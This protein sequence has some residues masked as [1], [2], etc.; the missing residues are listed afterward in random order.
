MAKPKKQVRTV[1]AER[2][3]LKDSDGRT[4]AELSTEGSLAVLAL[5]DRDE[6]RQLVLFAGD[7]G[8]SVVLHTANGEQSL[9]L[10][11]ISGRV[12]LISSAK[13]GKQKV[14][15]I[16]WPDG[17]AGWSIRAGHRGSMAD[18]ILG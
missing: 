13:R 10:D 14:A 15:L 6:R 2:F 18:K 11:T 7:A 17:S 4:R 5:N 12:G 8:A 1:E 16:V 3:V 9:S